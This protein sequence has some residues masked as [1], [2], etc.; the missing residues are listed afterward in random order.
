MT[1]CPNCGSPISGVQCEYCGTTFLDLVDVSAG[2]RCIV[3]LRHGSNVITGEMYVNSI[4]AEVQYADPVFGRD[5]TGR[6]HR[7][8]KASAPL[9]KMNM[10]FISLGEVTI[11]KVSDN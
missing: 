1:N 3:R 10:E 6:L 8:E 7:I 5:F 9:V 4:D 11:K 2:G